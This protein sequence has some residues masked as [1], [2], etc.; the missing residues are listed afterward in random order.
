[1]GCKKIHFQGLDCTDQVF[2]IVEEADDVQ[3]FRLFTTVLFD[4]EAVRDKREPVSSG[5]KLWSK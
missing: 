2:D 4:D 5:N 3:L 1:M